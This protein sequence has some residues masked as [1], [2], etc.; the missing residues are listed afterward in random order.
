MTEDS[1]NRPDREFERLG[2]VTT[3]QNLLRHFYA[4][5]RQDVVLGPI[6]DSRIHD[7]PAHLQKIGSFWARQLGAPSDYPGGFAG[8]HLSLGIQPEHVTRWL[9]LWERNCRQHLNPDSAEWMITRAHDIATHL[10]RI[11]A[12]ATG[13]Q[14]TRAVTRAV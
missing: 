4:D 9:G 3:L 12:G 10:R 14:I 2:G 8:A 1:L 11:V 6:F 13:L 7:W 5:I